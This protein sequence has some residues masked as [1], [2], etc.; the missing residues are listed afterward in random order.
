M[1][2]LSE[3]AKTYIGATQGDKRHKEIIDYYN[4]FI[5]PLPRGYRM[6]YS[7]NWCSCFVSVIQAKTGVKNPLYECSCRIML[8]NAKK[9]KQT[10]SDPKINDLIFY[11]WKDNGSIDHVGIITDIKGD[12]L[13]VIEGNYSKSVKIRTISKK[14][15]QI[16]NYARLSNI[17]TVEPT[18]KQDELVKIAKDVIKGKYGVGQARINALGENYK[19]VQAIVNELLRKK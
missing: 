5:K 17:S 13:Y 12:S 3:M 16:E 14:D 4:T 1:S 11:D 19:Q 7:D 2:T 6:K 9:A 10:I 18:D 15:K 8:N